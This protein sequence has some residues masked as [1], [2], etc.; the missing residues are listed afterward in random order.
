MCQFS[1]KEEKMCNAKR[2][3]K[4][5]VNLEQFHKNKKN[6]FKKFKSQNSSALKLKKKKLKI[7]MQTCFGNANSKFVFSK[8]NSVEKC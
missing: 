6:Y 1:K 7:K 4:K 8:Q 2:N 3:S 5:D